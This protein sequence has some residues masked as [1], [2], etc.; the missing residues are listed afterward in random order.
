[1]SRKYCVIKE[2]ERMETLLSIVKSNYCSDNKDSL[3]EVN[4]EH[5]LNRIF[6]ED[7]KDIIRSSWKDL[8][9]LIGQEIRLLENNC[10]KSFIN[11]LYKKSKDM[12]FIVKINPQDDRTIINFNSTN[13][14]KLEHKFIEI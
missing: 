6:N 4:L 3:Q 2:N 12:I 11:R 8:E 14:L 9:M 13:S 1:M 5:V 10:K 7:I